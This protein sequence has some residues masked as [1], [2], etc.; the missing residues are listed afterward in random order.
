MEHKRSV[1]LEKTYLLQPRWCPAGGRGPAETLLASCRLAQNIPQK[2]HKLKMLKTFDS[3]ENCTLCCLFTPVNYSQT[4]LSWVPHFGVQH[5]VQMINGYFSGA[6][7][8]QASAFLVGQH[9]AAII[10][11]LWS[12][13][14]LSQKHHPNM[15]IIT[16]RHKIYPLTLQLVGKCNA[17]YQLLG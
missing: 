5:C 1:K 3:E 14:C 10:I 7:D 15:N 17:Q 6:V 11:K 4:S 12:L 2:L 8:P 16:L 9:S 13:S